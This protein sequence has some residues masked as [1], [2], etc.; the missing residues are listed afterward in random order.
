MRACFSSR[1]SSLPLCQN[2]AII[3]F[4]TALL[5]F[6]CWHCKNLLKTVSKISKNIFQTNKHK[7]KCNVVRLIY[8]QQLELHNYKA[9]ALIKLCQA[10]TGLSINQGLTSWGW[11]KPCSESSLVRT[12]IRFSASSKIYIN[13]PH[14]PQKI[15]IL[16]KLDPLHVKSHQKNFI[17][18]GWEKA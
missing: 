3:K 10:Q 12:R 1:G 7:W 2:N 15:E 8:N 16:K 11:A 17:S 18:K 13:F 6:G 14:W 9:Q 5:T 4:Q